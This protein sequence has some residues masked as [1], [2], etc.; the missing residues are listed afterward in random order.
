MVRCSILSV[1]L[2]LSMQLFAHDHEWVLVTG[3]NFPPYTDSGYPKGGLF[4]E[5]VDAVMSNMTSANGDYQIKWLPWRRGYL[6]TSSGKYIAT[7]PYVYTPERA[8][9]LQYSEPLVVVEE[10]I[11]SQAKDPRDF[12]KI[13]Q[14]NDLTG[15]KPLG[16]N[17]N[18][19]QKFIDDG[20]MELLWVDSLDTCF[21][22]LAQG[23][24]DLVDID[25]YVGF[26]FIKKLQLKPME[27]KMHQRVLLQ[28]TM[29]VVVSRKHPKADLFLHTFNEALLKVKK[30]SIYKQILDSYLR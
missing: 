22:L 11:F 3:S 8:E 25:K 10:R 24:V 1:T 30:A 12:N 14:F 4:V 2:V 20:H 21:Q 26:A 23:R 7:F 13:E 18:A 17:V 28:Q 19:V 6:E 29:H 16:Y 9:H 5:L 15:C 27:F